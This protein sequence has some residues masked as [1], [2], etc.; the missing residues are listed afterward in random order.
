MQSGCVTISNK[1]KMAHKINLKRYPLLDH[2][3]RIELLYLQ[4]QLFPTAKQ[5]LLRH[6][7]ALFRLTFY[8][9]QTNLLRVAETDS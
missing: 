2:I 1:R 7:I 4:I 8:L 9:K 3:F 5:I 6:Y